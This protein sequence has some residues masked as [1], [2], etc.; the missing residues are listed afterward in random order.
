MWKG[1]RKYSQLTTSISSQL[2][3]GGIKSI[4]LVLLVILLGLILYI[5]KVALG[6]ILMTVFHVLTDCWMRWDTIVLSW[7]VKRYIRTGFSFFFPFRFQPRKTGFSSSSLAPA[8]FF[9]IPSPLSIRRA[10]SP[11]ID[12]ENLQEERE[13]DFRPSAEEGLR[14][15]PNP[16]QPTPHPEGRLPLVEAAGKAGEDWSV[17]K[18]WGASPGH[19]H[20]PPVHPPLGWTPVPR[21]NGGET[22]FFFCQPPGFKLQDCSLI[23][24]IGL[25][26]PTKN[27]Y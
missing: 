19:A 22:S 21:L 23:N 20:H 8:H 9:H 15:G 14:R 17:G 2:L 26:P 16:L 1:W 11:E 25:Q 6:E 5:K 3:I 18:G 24:G 10:L 12:P 7:A 4:G 13:M 27:S